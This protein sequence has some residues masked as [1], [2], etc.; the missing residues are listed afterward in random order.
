MRG[1]IVRQTGSW[2]VART[3]DGQFFDCKVKGNFRLRG[4][5]STNPVAVGD[6]VE[7][8]PNADG[9][10]LI[11][12][13]HDR[14]NYIVRRA[15]NLSKQCHVIAANVDQVLL[16]VTI[17]HPET[18]TT[19]VDRFLATA[20]AYRIP[21]LIAFNKTDIYDADETKKMKGMMSLYESLHYECHA[22][23]S[24]IGATL[25]PLIRSLQGRTT[26]LSGNSGVGKSTLLNTLS[27]DVNART[28][29]IS[30]AH[31]KGMHTTTMSEMFS[32]PFGGQ[33]I[34]TPGI[35]GFGTYDMRPEEISHY[36]REIFAI[37]ADCRFHNCTHTRE[38]DCAVLRAI[39]EGRIA[40][41]RYASYLSM[42]QTDEKYRGVDY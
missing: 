25:Q 38:P 23:S 29:E 34:D 37:G 5:R 22:I 33:I 15:S 26:L 12:E 24:I 3:D 31:D 13:I 30:A 2:H 35:K 18:S 11:T 28:A 41:S 20:E 32:L 6:F 21:V 39:E 8:L 16:M 42:L 10:A 19:F 9:T 36:F 14:R 4:I 17:A 7:V 1:L 40:P 27:P